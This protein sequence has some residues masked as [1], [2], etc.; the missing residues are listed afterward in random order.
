MLG[1]AVHL[2]FVVMVDAVAVAVLV[3]VTLMEVEVMRRV[4]KVVARGIFRIQRDAFALRCRAILPHLIDEEDFGHVVDDEH[5]G[6][7]RDR[8]SLSTAEMNVHDENGE[9]G[10][11]CDHRHRRYVVL[12]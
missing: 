7:V 2:P 5:L 4:I 6:P 9:R 11:G 10:G 12:P 3:W 1:D 8:L